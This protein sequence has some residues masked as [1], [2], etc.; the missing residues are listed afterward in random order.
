VSSGDFGLRFRARG[1]VCRQGKRA[2]PAPAARRA[3]ARATRRQPPP[4]PAA[5]HRHEAPV[6]RP[7]SRPPRGH[8]FLDTCRAVDGSGEHRQNRVIQR[9]ITPFLIIRSTV[10]SGRWPGLAEPSRAGAGRRVGS[11][12]QRE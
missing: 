12:R 10:S 6:R 1:A 11:S 3:F 4:A 5:A 7:L 8:R 9:V 2:R